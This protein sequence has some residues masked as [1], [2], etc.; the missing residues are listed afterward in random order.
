[1]CLAKEATLAPCR[2]RYGS[3]IPG[4]EFTRPRRHRSSLPSALAASFHDASNG[5]GVC[6]DKAPTSPPS[7]CASRGGP[8][9][10]RYVLFNRAGEDQNT[11]FPDEPFRLI[12]ESRVSGRFTSQFLCIA[13]PSHTSLQRNA[14]VVFVKAKSVKPFAAMSCVL[15]LFRARRFLCRDL[16]GGLTT[17]VGPRG[18]PGPGRTRISRMS[19]FSAV[20][21][22]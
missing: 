20:T 13:V 18:F 12:R 4:L 6:C 10:W 14:G 7:N 11:R 22:A 17:P 19:L 15:G 9:E 3:K 1:M 21:N 2:G 8:P 16:Q 5:S